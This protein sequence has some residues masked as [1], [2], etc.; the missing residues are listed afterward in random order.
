MKK[1]FQR[2]NRIINRQESQ[3]S[4]WEYEAAGPQEETDAGPD[5]LSGKTIVR[6][7]HVSHETIG[8]LQQH[9]TYLDEELLKRK[10]I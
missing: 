3:Y 1:C 6:F 4:S 9:I 5:Q 7:I 8:G 10:K 2:L